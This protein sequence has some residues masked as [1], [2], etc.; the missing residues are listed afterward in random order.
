MNEKGGNHQIL[1]QKNSQL[2]WKFIYQ[3]SPVSRVEIAKE[4]GL[5]TPT[6]TG[7]VTPLI[8]RGLVRETVATSEES[9]GAGRPR[10]MLEFVPEAYYICGVDV[11]PYRINYILTDL[12]G[13]VLACRRTKQTLDEYQKTLNLL[14]EQ[15]DIL[16]PNT[17]DN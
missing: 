15:I 17:L 12:L 1:K 16:L 3:N 13:N 11:G 5:T 8:S 2:V 7:M 10:M 9:K 14:S 6:I 4:L